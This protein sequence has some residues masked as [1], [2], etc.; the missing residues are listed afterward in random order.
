MN[1]IIKIKPQEKILVDFFSKVE[2]ACF[3]NDETGFLIK[4]NRLIIFLPYLKPNNLTV[5]FQR[6]FFDECYQFFS[7]T[8][9]LVLLEYI[10]SLNF[11]T[12]FVLL[13][14]YE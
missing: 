2:T 11:K 10:N 3:I 13:K 8:K 1:L 5:F 12:A 9:T 14:V 6:N 4:L 7:N